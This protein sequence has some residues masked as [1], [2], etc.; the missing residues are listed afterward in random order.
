MSTSWLWFRPFRSERRGA[1]FAHNSGDTLIFDGDA[2]LLLDRNGKE[3]RVGTDEEIEERTQLGTPA[4]VAISD[5]SLHCACYFKGEGDGDGAH[6]LTVYNRRGK[7]VA[8]TTLNYALEALVFDTPET[9]LGTVDQEQVQQM[10]SEPLQ[11]IFPISKGKD[12]VPEIDPQSGDLVS[13]HKDH[14]I[15]QR[16][17]LTYEIQR[18]SKPR[19]TFEAKGEIRIVQ[20]SPTGKSFSA[21]EG[22]NK[23]VTYSLEG[24]V[25]G[26]IEAD[27]DIDYFRYYE[28]GSIVYSCN[29]RLVKIAATGNLL[30]KKVHPNGVKGSSRVDADSGYFLVYFEAEGA[31]QTWTYDVFGN[32]LCKHSSSYAHSSRLFTPAKAIW[33]W[34]RGRVGQ[35]S[36][37]GDEWD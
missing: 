17:D 28:D 7:P 8:H 3:T 29:D 25:L 36:I 19:A 37:Y 32:V 14:S 35:A 12:L 24:Q 23:I 11:L 9:V 34:E 33:L 16:G 18:R 10:F 15:H 13:R 20:F 5:T 30:W 27:N 26:V 22:V 31:Y 1:A 2:L 6:A 21:L 4:L